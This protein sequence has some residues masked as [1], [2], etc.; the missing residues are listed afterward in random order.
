MNKRMYQ[1]L[2]A[3]CV[4]MNRW[5]PAVCGAG[6]LCLPLRAEA[7][8][9]SGQVVTPLPLR[10]TVTTKTELP[11]ANPPGLTLHVAP[12]GDDKGPGTAGRPFASLERARDEIRS[13]RRNGG[14]PR[15]D[16]SICLH[17]GEYAVSRTLLLS[18]EDS[19][20]EAAP[21]RYCAAPG[22]KVLLRGGV[23]LS[24][25]KR[26]TDAT[27]Y[28]L[29]PRGSLG[30]VWY[31][32]MKGAGITNPL[33]L[34]LGGFASGN[35]FTTHPAHELFFDG[36]ALQ[37]ARGPNTG[38]L[39]I[40]D[41]VV[42]DGT[43]GYD[44]A[45][46]KTGIFTYQG[47]VPSKWAA[48]PDLLLY[49]YW[50]WDWADS[51]ERVAGIDA[52]QRVITL[53]RP[54]HSYGFRIGAPFYAYNALSELDQPGEWYMDRVNGRILI[55][56]P[57]DPTRATVEVSTLATA[58]V[59]MENV[60]NVCFEGLTWELG[61]ADAIHVRGGSNCSFLGC[62]IRH[63]AGDALGVRGGLHHSLV[64]C[65]V[66]SMGR[67][68]IS[69]SGGNRKT[70]SPGRHLVENCDIHDLSR[71][72]HTYTPAIILDGVGNQV[73]HNRLHDIG[74]SAIRLEG[75]EHIVELN[76]IY[77][78]V[79]E[80]DDQG[81]IDM[82]G[83][84]TYR[85]NVIRYNY[86]HHIGNW[87]G[88]G[89][90]PACGQ[91]AIRL[92]DAICGTTIRG[93]IFERCS[94]GKLGFGGVQIHGGK[95][96]VLEGNLFAD[97]MAMVSCSPWDELRWREFVKSALEDRQIDRERYL[98][99]YPELAHLLENVNC[100]HVRNNRTIHCQEL[101]RRAPANLDAANNI[102]LT[103]TEL[104]L[105]PGNPLFTQPGFERIPVEEMG[106]YADAW[107]KLQS[108][109]ADPAPGKSTNTDWLKEAGH[110]VFMHF[111][112]GDAKG[113][114]LVEKFDVEAL[115]AQLASVGAKYFVLTLGQN[116]GY[117]NA[118][119]AA[120]GRRTGYAPGQRCSARDLPLDLYHALQ[121]KGIRLMLYLPCQAPNGDARAQ[122]AYGL[123]QGRQDQPIDLAFAEKWSEVIQ[124]WSDRY[125]DKVSGWWFD[126][127][128][129]HI[130]F[131]EAIAARYALAARHGNPKAIVTFNP[132]VKVIHYTQAEDY[133]AGELNEPFGTIPASR[134]LKGSQWHVL[135]YLGSS[136][137]RRDT[138]YEPDRWARWVKRVVAQGGAVTLDAGPNWDPQAAPIGSLAES[139]ML[140]LKA[141]H[142]AVD[143]QQGSNLPK[144][145]KRAESYFGIHFDFHAGLDCRE[146]G[147]NTTRAMIEK[148]IAE[149]RPD[150][151]QIDCKGHPGLSSYPT[152]VGNP[153][154]G[155]VGD[156][157]RLWRSVTAEHGVGL[158]MHYSG[159]WDS[160]AIRLHSD[161]AVV[162]A[163]GKADVNA[164][165][166]F[167]P[168]AG[169]LLIPQLRELA[170]EYGVDG[171]WVDGEC[172]ASKADYGKAA[173]NAFRAATGIQEAPR[174][175]GDPHWHEFLQFNR[176]AFRDYLRN[177]I[178]E[179]KK[180]N[181]QM[182]LC[183]NWAFTDHMPEAVCA[184]VDWISGDFSP[185]D[186]INSAR[187][188]GR[189][190]AQ[191]GKPWDLMAWGFVTR[192]ARQNGSPHK[193][194]VQLQREAAIVLSLGGGFQ[195]YYNQRRDGSVPEEHLPVIAEVA[196]FCRDRQAVCQG[197]VP[198]PQIALLYS[199][200]SHYREIDGLFNRDLSR[201]AG[202]L[203]SLLES[204]QVVDVVS[205]HRL[206]GRMAEY[207]L[208]IVAECD[209]LEPA[210]KAELVGYVQQGGN[211]LLI[212]PS[213]A[214]LFATELGVSLQG[215]PR[216]EP[217]Y[218]SYAGAMHS[219]RDLSQT[220]KLQSKAMAF[221]QLHDSKDAH[222]ASQPAASVA[223]LGRGKIAA[224]YFSFSRG[225]LGDRS[226]K[227][228][229]YLNE[230]VRQ[231]FPAPLVEVN[232]SPHVDVAVNRVHGKLAIN[233]VNTSGR[234]WDSGQSLI[235]SIAP[236]GPLEVTLR[237]A[238]KPVAMTLEPGGQAIA[239]EYRDGKARCTVP[240][241]EVHAVIVVQ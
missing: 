144:R 78:V 221:G 45:G 63:F 141:V 38:F 198:V 7:E 12:G 229:A 199:T 10:E 183:S 97:C 155:F 146:I 197:A 207:P 200:A 30:K 33:P 182:Q 5:L 99:V 61:S 1:S 16:A 202:T 208:I 211:L 165:S 158:Y 69:I 235:D 104:S 203:Q 74:S 106:V 172:W 224:T 9:A 234:H 237:A 101:Y 83:N 53:A 22:E 21:V 11:A 80:S 46:S 48:E 167:G 219:T 179:V 36:K 120:Y 65:D 124:E 161:W 60:S 143:A 213:A 66:Y 44:R 35:G 160:Q 122:Q 151:I 130:R 29:L 100:N 181:P 194:A 34:K 142:A 39:R 216:A 98:R 75:N 233:L 228:G 2:R 72:D 230:L 241:L 232:G 84:P 128:Y 108:V 220:A 157:L 43:K 137:A 77:N 87:R 91:C 166:F 225:Y 25:W 164:T 195:S 116:S 57:S 136:W 173:L 226:P 51:Y 86:W 94:A 169:E 31:L 150:Y 215:A 149:A 192:G 205:E 82:W 85:G 170:G 88:T 188:S 184:P 140:A 49:G 52:K 111:L 20:T 115:A 4:K 185:E 147:K 17:G 209:F 154:P 107:R 123:A 168:Y 204:Q 190:L 90:V 217:R 145:L 222:S 119:N 177:Y 70:L 58:M 218:I 95:D 223:A 59:E 3:E 163:D 201:I 96:N 118:P 109:A 103:D 27:L 206:A 68:G 238:N 135:T 92:D 239:F 102:R 171:A 148:I 162:N 79:T 127:G 134:W 176:A 19:G 64:S 180:T 6:L 26:L 129:E 28:P 191:Q 193:S 139:Q 113:L 196:R 152:K 41:V 159:V 23:R 54:W 114:A 189:Y 131:N 121:P 212:G 175:P 67:G 236:I 15:G 24:G 8:T 93:N 186:S 62:T 89:E 240:R 32:E 73:R 126:G 13:L 18:A 153:A 231:L 210:F 50:F 178:R 14:L 125:A 42:K 105:K 110:G 117:F 81:G 71:I 133:T 56:P 37:L 76:E 214:S 138:R 112:P 132:G 55:Y 47:D 174:K 227:A 187:L 40:A 156:P